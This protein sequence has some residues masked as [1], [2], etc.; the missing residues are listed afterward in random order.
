MMTMSEEA[1]KPFKGTI[2][3]TTIG[4]PCRNEWYELAL[5]EDGLPPERLE[6]GC[7]LGTVIYNRSGESM[8]GTWYYSF[9]LLNSP[10][11]TATMN[12]GEIGKDARQH[13]AP[14]VSRRTSQY[15]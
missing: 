7:P 3:A 8:K 1:L 2:R 12:R 10:R 11:D 5:D 9:D 15:N 6:F 13:T 14:P 4:G